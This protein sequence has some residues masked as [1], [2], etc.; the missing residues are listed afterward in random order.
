[1]SVTKSLDVVRS[2]GQDV[3]FVLHPPLPSPDRSK[4]LRAASVSWVSQYPLEDEMLFAP[5]TI[6]TPIVAPRAWAV[7]AELE[8]RVVMHFRTEVKRHMVMS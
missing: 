2:F 3:V 4:M 6:L 7:P 5:D 8:G 1:M